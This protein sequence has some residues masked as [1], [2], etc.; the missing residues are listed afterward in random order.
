MTD[1]IDVGTV[2]VDMSRPN[3]V[4]FPSVPVKDEEAYIFFLTKISPSNLLEFGYVLILPELVFDS[5]SA[6]LG[7]YRLKYFDRGVSYCF[8]V[9]IPKGIDPSG[10]LKIALKPIK[11]F[12][13]TTPQPKILNFRLQILKDTQK[14]S[15]G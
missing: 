10:V 8:P 4:F 15:Y 11:F 2:Q 14:I 12:S 3:L 13:N 6:E 7:N 9:T 1:L 5:I